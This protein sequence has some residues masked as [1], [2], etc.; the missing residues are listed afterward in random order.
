M[1][2]SGF[3]LI[4]KTD[5]LCQKTFVLL[6]VNNLKVELNVQ[7]CRGGSD[8]PFPPCCKL[9]ELLHV[10]GGLL[11]AQRLLRVLR[12]I[13][14]IIHSSV[15]VTKRTEAAETLS[16]LT[17]IQGC[18][19]LSWIVILFLWSEEEEEIDQ[20]RWDQI[21][22]WEDSNSEIGSQARVFRKT[23]LFWSFNSF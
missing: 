7:K 14:T 18:W 5:I 23:Y 6:L 22:L 9:L 15:C 1:K 21:L 8:L 10:D 3:K 11:P 2:W 20:I 19:R 13:V 17:L 16:S 4:D 12:L